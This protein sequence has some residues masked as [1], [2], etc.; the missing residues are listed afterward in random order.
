MTTPIH[1]LRTALGAC[2]L[3]AAAI[4]AGCSTTPTTRLHS[5]VAS[6]PAGSGAAASVAPTL[7]WELVGVSVPAQVD[8]QQIVLRLPDDTFVLLEHERWVAPLADEIR[9]ALGLRLSQTNLPSAGSTASTW[10]IALDLRRFDARLGVRTVL[11][12]D[13]TIRPA[14]GP[15]AQ[16]RC[17]GVFE[18]PVKGSVADVVAGHRANVAR[19]GDALSAGL[20]ALAAGRPADCSTAGQ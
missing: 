2:V 17:R 18:Q 14:Q 15:G 11:E 9:A 16:L 7:A 1:R 12:A 4:A 10:Q 6:A 13:W 5:L 20:A 3:I 19:L 8:V